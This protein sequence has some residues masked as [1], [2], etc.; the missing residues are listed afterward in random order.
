MKRLFVL[1][2]LLC[3][4]FAKPVGAYDFY[5]DYDDGVRIY[6][7]DVSINEFAKKC[8]VVSGDY[9]YSGEL[10]IPD[11][12]GIYEVVGI[13][14]N[15]FNHNDG[16]TKITLP[17]NLQYI[18]TGAFYL[19][20]GLKEIILPDNL[21][22]IYSN[23]FQ[24]CIG[25]TKIRITAASVNSNAFDN[26]TNLQTI[27]FSPN[28]SL[29]DSWTF[30]NCKNIKNIIFEDGYGEVFLGYGGE[31][32][33]MSYGLFHGL[34][35]DSVYVGR[36]L[37]Y[38]ATSEKNGPFYGTGVGKPELGPMVSTIPPFW[39]SGVKMS[40]C[41]I[42][43]KVTHIA[44]Y[45]FYKAD[46]ERVVLPEALKKI[47]DYAFYN[48]GVREIVQ[49]EVN[50]L[51]EIGE[52]AFEGCHFQKF[53]LP[54]GFTEIKPNSF[55]SCS[56]LEEIDIPQ[57]VTR[58]GKYAFDG[59]YRLKIFNLPESLD[60]LGAFALAGTATESISM[61][62][63]V[64]YIHSGL[65]NN[66]DKLV[67]VELHNGII[68]IG[69]RA[70]EG[71]DALESIKIP[72]NIT[73]FSERVFQ[74]CTKLKEINVPENL[75][76]IRS[77]AF[78]G[79]KSLLSIEL[80][81][82]LYELGYYSFRGCGFISFT[83]PEKINYL[84]AG[85][86]ENCK[87]LKSVN[88][89][90][91]KSDDLGY[92]LNGTFAGCSSIESITI[93]QSIHFIFENAFEG[94]TSLK[95]IHIEKSE[96]EIHFSTANDY[97]TPLFG[98]SPLES[99]KI[100]RNVNLRGITY[101]DSPKSAFYGQTKLKNVELVGNMTEIPS[102]IFPK[103]N[104]AKIVISDRINSIKT[105]AF[106]STVPDTVICEG[107]KP[108]TLEL[109]ALSDA[110]VYVPNGAGSNYRNIE[111]WNQNL[112]IDQADT[113]S[114][115]RVRYPGAIIAS[116][117]QSGIM[118]PEN[119]TK[120]KIEGRIN[121]SDWMVLKENMPLLY[122][123]DLSAA[124]IDSIPSNQ[125]KNDSKLKE[126][127][128]PSSIKCIG[129]YAFSGCNN[130]FKESITFESCEY[131][132]KG[133][134]EN[135]KIT[136]VVFN[137]PVEIETE[138]FANSALE[139]IIFKKD[140]RIGESAL[141]DCN[142][143]V[144]VKFGGIASIG[145]F[146]FSNCHQ[147]ES[148]VLPEVV[149]SIGISAFAN[150]NNLVSVIF[151]SKKLTIGE[152]AFENCVNLLSLSLNSDEV[153]IRPY[154]F[155]NTGIQNLVLGDGVKEIGD[156]AFS[157][158]TNL[159]SKVVLPPSVKKVSIGVFLNCS[160]LESVSLNDSVNKIDVEAFAG[161]SN[162][163]YINLP[164]SLRTIGENAF[165][166]C[167]NLEEIDIPF[168]L[169]DFNGAFQNCNIKKLYAHW[170]VPVLVGESTFNGLDEDKCIL[171][172]PVNSAV[173]YLTTDVWKIFWNIEENPTD[174]VEKIS[175]ADD[176]VR[177]ICVDNWDI[178]KDG[179]IGVDEILR[180]NDL[181]NTFTNNTSIVNL[182]DF[183]W[184]S[185]IK[186]INKNT[187]SGCVNLNSISIPAS[188]INIDSR[189]FDDNVAL[190]NIKIATDNPVYDSRNNSN[191]IIITETNRLLRG[192]KNTVI[193]SSI[194][195]ISDSAF[196][197]CSGLTRMSIPDN[198]VNVGNSAFERCVNL[199]YIYI[200][201]K[202][203][204]ISKGT[205]TGCTS[206]DTLHINSNIILYT[207][208]DGG[209]YSIKD[210]F[211]NSFKHVE[212]G[213][214]IKLIPSDSFKD[215]LSLETVNIT[216][217]CDS[218]GDSAFSGC[219]NLKAIT[220]PDSLRTI[221]RSLF[222]GCSKLQSIRIPN[223]VT[224][225]KNSA[226]KGC[227]ALDSINIPA[228]IISMGYSVFQNCSSLKSVI[229]PNITEIPT[230][231]FLS[232]TS[233]KNV[234]MPNT[235][236]KIGQSAF[237]GCVSLDSIY[238][239]RGLVEIGGGAF[240][241]SNINSINIPCCDVAGNAFTS[242]DIN[243]LT[244][245]RNL[246]T[247]CDTIN[248]NGNVLMPISLNI[249]CS[250]KGIDFGCLG[251][252][253]KTIEVSYGSNINDDKKISIPANA[254]KGCSALKDLYLGENV[255]DIG[256]RAF[257]DCTS[258]DTLILPSKITTIQD[259]V[260]MNCNWL[261]KVE[262]P[263]SITKIGKSA[264]RNCTRLDSLYLSR[265]LELIDEYAFNGSLLSKLNMPCCNSG[266]NAFTGC[267]IR[268]LT[269]EKNPITGC[270]SIPFFHANI[271][272]LVSLSLI[273]CKLPGNHIFWYNNSL[274]TVTIGNDYSGESSEVVIPTNA[275][276]GCDNLQSVYLG[277]NVK[278]I[279]D[280]AFSYC[281][282]LK[283]ITLT[284]GLEKI[285]KS[286]FDNTALDTIRIPQTVVTMHPI[287]GID[288]VYV[289]WKE[290][291]YV[292]GNLSTS[293]TLHVP[294]GT[295]AKYKSAPY[296]KDFKI[297]EIITPGD[298]NNDSVVNVTD[299]IGIVN[300]ILKNTPATFIETAADV[301]EDGTINVTDAI[302]VV[303]K[304]LNIDSGAK[305]N[306]VREKSFVEPQ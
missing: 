280:N 272:R 184:F 193:P 247:G 62:I 109:D 100:E 120:V 124:I 178:T 158:C 59:C 185:R 210:I 244:I 221:S 285:G 188:V 60:S 146:A 231:T 172:V 248:F 3:L 104:I 299:A 45:A 127:V 255:I 88:F 110:V 274:N 258:L 164:N 306:Y 21:Q 293:R 249:N 302:G 215:C 17:S 174:V 292:D 102:F 238:L 179:E 219:A 131:V 267:T 204:N 67:N 175:F 199:E 286:V 86:L 101:D 301:N 214:N 205:F 116:F 190:S 278:S 66:C 19:C 96:K 106:S 22:E 260:F 134:F 122:Y 111:T 129:D 11:S 262:M 113:I 5:I 246:L 224:C 162:L 303:N 201:E 152:K 197:N 50:N 304:I 75:K 270:D 35:L 63:G 136:N 256:D 6:Y 144:N 119:V 182:N 138:S 20:A 153:I 276:K 43:S 170:Q 149:D 28:V 194:K 266:D 93:P 173:N 118:D 85:V 271:Q 157:N 253:K 290:P 73:E 103:C 252:N 241:S 107:F 268:Y 97:P 295:A 83:F 117:K 37:N 288:H 186:E 72:N 281:R 151:P 2:F 105:N 217:N 132:G 160:Q 9:R 233:L 52:Y 128:L 114:T 48:A 70:F 226:F 242:C 225:I 195:E 112:I 254:F 287:Y 200:G 240:G 203:S 161:C 139:T 275:F 36:G 155:A 196:Y 47:G 46:I 80:P 90:T 49:P 227:V 180:I 291:I 220:I 121:D 12:A 235:I 69:S 257:M 168:F 64:E 296:W 218:I 289:Q 206:L 212:L 51:K 26:C 269:I 98:Y 277:T 234:L 294:A 137:V 55:R 150:C 298:V 187:F 284:N 163:K 145:D 264:F 305:F 92:S 16:L 166:G 251:K 177:K 13:G 169:V 154:A 189:A 208:K 125:F 250:F 265:G 84:R 81:K 115:V 261:T 279:G 108:A 263:N 68:G 222:E 29:V 300:Y 229:L 1:Q 18:R 133:A 54:D 171:T 202:C 61:P 236:I 33:D 4:L 94:C 223:E 143:L 23:A 273:N 44:K 156:Y 74:G 71:C 232:C 191:A 58:I 181:G 38:N 15:A 159:E 14:P 57:T 79:C 147:L 30:T 126:L 41:T 183:R 230:N 142:K 25:L 123:I 245:E 91:V 8:E 34:S 89:P 10:V 141:R 87:A 216:N 239:S 77:N 198:V 259:S 209:I 148:V 65:F 56:M 165:S 7:N 82:Q 237:S 192:C 211:G 32:F 99:I 213:N 76:Y 207:K 283:S 27:I 243:K 135:T 297:V 176:A 31:N 40:E 39:Y 140:C 95:T 282:S 167:Y 228:N 53:K 130:F 24:Y 42:P 78:D